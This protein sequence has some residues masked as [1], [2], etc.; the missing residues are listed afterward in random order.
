MGW[1]WIK[2]IQW[3]VASDPRMICTVWHPEADPA[4][5]QAASLWEVIEVTADSV[6]SARSQLPRRLRRPKMPDLLLEHRF[7]PGHRFRAPHP[8][9]PMLNQLAVPTTVQLAKNFTKAMGGWAKAGFKTVKRKVY[10]QRHAICGAC[11]HWVPD[12]RVGAGMCRKCGCS[13]VKLWLATATCPDQPA[14]WE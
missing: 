11:E 9:T 3:E 12:A 13:G 2:L 1:D 7:P 10:E 6:A 8:A 14:R 4:L 5:V